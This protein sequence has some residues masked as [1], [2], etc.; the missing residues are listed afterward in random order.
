MS[1][2]IPPTGPV[3]VNG[4]MQIWQK[5]P[6]LN[7]PVAGAMKL[8]PSTY[9]PSVP[10][11]DPTNPY[12]PTWP[13]QSNSTNPLGLFRGLSWGYVNL[14]TTQGSYSVPKNLTY[15]YYVV[16][17]GGSGGPAEGPVAVPSFSPLAP[18]RYGVYGG[19]GGAGLVVPGT[20]A[21]TAANPFP[22][23]VGSG[24]QGLYNSG[25]LH[26]PYPTG[27]QAFGWTLVPGG[28][29][30]WANS[31]N[32]QYGDSVSGNSGGPAPYTWRGG[33]GGSSTNGGTDL[34][35]LPAASQTPLGVYYGGVSSSGQHAGGGGGAL[36][37]GY[38][39]NTGQAGLGVVF[40][41]PVTG[42]TYYLGFGGGGASNLP[43]NLTGSVPGATGTGTSGQ[44]GPQAYSPSPSTNVFYYGSGGGGA[45]SERYA[46]GNY[47]GGNGSPGCAIIYYP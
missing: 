46:G 22:I 44:N 19:G 11:N 36:Q 41:P 13:S 5:T 8:T 15:K 17:G 24:V 27:T 40:N 28:S 20:V 10:T 1:E 12:G 16:S 45:R 32:Q 26:G 4:I 3:P 21:L 33:V 18:T 37:Q 29:G 43:Y 31:A 35:G 23:Y 7:V 47:Y 9:L 42:A 6:T 25:P 2:T 30:G 38:S 39:P 34:A 14:I